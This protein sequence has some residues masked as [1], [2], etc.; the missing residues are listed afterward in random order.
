MADAPSEARRNVD[1]RPVRIVS[2]RPSLRQRLGSIWDSRELLWYF[3]VTDIKIKYK[4]S[5]LGLLWSLVA[6]TLTLAIYWFVFGV[7]I[8]NHVPDYV[9][10]LYSGL[11]VWGFFS[12]VVN[13]STGIVVDRAAVVKKVAFP[14]E[15]LALSTVGTGLIFF[16]IQSLVLFAFMLIT[17]H[18]PDWGLIWLLPIAIA[19]IAMFGATLGV[20]LSAA[21]VYLRD[22]KHLVEVVLQLWFFLTPILY[23]FEQ[24]L[25]PR[26][27]RYHITWLYLL[28]PVACVVMTFQRV[29]YADLVVPASRGGTGFIKVLP[30]WPA[31]TYLLAD[32]GLL[33]LSTIG[34]LVAVS[35]FGRLEGNFAEEL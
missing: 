28:N 9:I 14:R 22:T 10:F 34:M 6:P 16:A 4:S 31:T 21:N 1:D 5:A 20:L 35:I 8:N 33:V 19:A 32:L 27:H 13:T 30:T 23:S 26:L 18:G 25:S 7:I 17:W 12:N 11:L 29:F 24:M 15:I 2:A 3:V